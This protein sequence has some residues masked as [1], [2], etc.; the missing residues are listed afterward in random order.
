MKARLQ[1]QPAHPHGSPH[2]SCFDFMPPSSNLT[3]RPPLFYTCVLPLLW[4][5]IILN[6]GNYISVTLSARLP[7]HLLISLDTII[8]VLKTIRGII[9]YV[10][11]G[12]EAGLGRVTKMLSKPDLRSGGEGFGGSESYR[13][14]EAG[15][16]AHQRMQKQFLQ[17]QKQ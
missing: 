3:R 16:E 13:I 14:P 9:R 17:N 2:Q 10:E 11:H 4:R 12:Q 5:S 8:P 7:L 6:D 15:G 1:L